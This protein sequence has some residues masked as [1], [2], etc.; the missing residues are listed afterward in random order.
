MS[1]RRAG[2]HYDATM[3][4]Y[5][6][7]ELLPREA[8]KIST[9]NHRLRYGDGVFERIRLYNRRIRLDVSPRCVVPCCA[10]NAAASASGAS[11]QPA[12]GPCFRGW[13]G[14]RGVVRGIQDPVMAIPRRA[15]HFSATAV[16]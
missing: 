16:P 1:T 6:D 2:G 9:F 11:H 10:L 15:S 14:S 5:V 7:G 3:Q 4:L 8:A 12:K 13:R